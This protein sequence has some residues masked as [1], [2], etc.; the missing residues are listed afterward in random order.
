CRRW[1]GNTTNPHSSA[2]RNFID[3]SITVNAITTIILPIFLLSF[4]NV[5]LL[6]TL[7]NR[8]HLLLV[9]SNQRRE[10]QVQW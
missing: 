9:S 2:Y 7:R 4:L 10:L 8:R 6:C 5:L 1:F 3:V